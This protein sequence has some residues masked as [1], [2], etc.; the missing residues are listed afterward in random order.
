MKSWSIEQRMRMNQ[1]SKSYY[2][3]WIKP[4]ELNKLIQY[5]M[6][7]PKNYSSCYLEN[8][9][10]HIFESFKSHEPL[11]NKIS[12]LVIK[13]LKGFTMT[14]YGSINRADIEAGG[15]GLVTPTFI[16]ITSA[17]ILVLKNFHY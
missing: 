17:L 12:P 8:L 6:D 9:A 3:N 2:D 5:D 7:R 11:L 15:S 14:L 10:D 4:P 16:E 1:L 13:T